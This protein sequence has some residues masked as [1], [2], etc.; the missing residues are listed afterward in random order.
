MSTTWCIYKHT[1]KIN[2]KCY[3]GQTCKKPNKRFGKNGYGYINSHQPKFRNA[4]SKYGWDNFD[5]TILKENIQSLEE[6]HKW[7]KYYINLFDSFKN[8]YNS[9]LGGSGSEGKIWT[10]EEREKIRQKLKKYK[11]PLVHTYGK[12]GPETSMWGKHM[13]L[14]SNE[15]RRQKMLGRK[16]SEE[17]KEKMRLA[18]LGKKREPRTAEWKKQRSEAMKGKSNPMYG[19]NTNN[20]ETRVVLQYTL[21]GKFVREWPSI[22]SAYLGTGIRHIG[23]CCNKTRHYKTAGNYIWRFKNEK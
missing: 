7:E 12:R 5:H 20:H 18:H 17:A 21:D 6:A 11:G 8:G 13:S 1:N 22:K 9:T 16:M 2:G 4:I 19:K 3:I 14:E 15:K 23:E 10:K